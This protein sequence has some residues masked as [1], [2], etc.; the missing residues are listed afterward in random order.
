MPPPPVPRSPRKDTVIEDSTE[1]SLRQI[2][3]IKPVRSGS[4]PP[5][6]ASDRRPSQQATGQPSPAQA[7]ERRPLQQAA[8][9]QPPAQASDRGLFQ[10]PVGRLPSAQAS[11]RRLFQLAAGP[12]VV[13]EIR[14]NF[15][16]S[17]LTCYFWLVT[18]R[19]MGGSAHESGHRLHL[20]HPASPPWWCFHTHKDF[21][22]Q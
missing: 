13:C 16:R 20:V 18:V 19:R 1:A 5:A 8:G 14:S 7:S 21:H 22:A 15:L 10:R 9:Q 3:D 4:Q 6:Q 17:S 11:D 2:G 12:I